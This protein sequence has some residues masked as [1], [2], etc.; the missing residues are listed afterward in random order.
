MS[1]KRE[2]KVINIL[3]KGDGWR[4]ILDDHAAGKLEGSIT[5]GTNDVFVSVPFVDIT[6]HMHKLDDF[7]A[8]EK[9]RYSTELCIVEANKRPEMKFYA[10]EPF[11][12]I[13]HLQEY[14]LKEIV[15]HFNMCYFA[16]TIDYMLA[17]AIKHEELGPGDTIN[18]YGVNMSVLKEYEDERPGVEHWLGRAMG[19]GIKVNLQHDVTSLFKTKTGLLYGYLI[20][21]WRTS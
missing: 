21:Q 3:G 20:E 8:N 18:L 19:M 9:T 15:D 5:Y 13:P 6:F 1:K 2:P 10:V 17:Y 7:L 11:D 12:A 16:C 14:P 4:R